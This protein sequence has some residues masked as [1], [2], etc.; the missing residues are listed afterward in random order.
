MTTVLILV[1]FQIDANFDVNIPFFCKV[2]AFLR[3]CIDEIEQQQQ[4]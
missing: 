3:V 2:M 1:P 4:S